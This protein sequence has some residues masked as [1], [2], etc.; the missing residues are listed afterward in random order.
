[1]LGPQAH[2]SGPDFIINEEARSHLNELRVHLAA[3]VGIAP[4]SRY[5][6]DIASMV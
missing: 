3:E 5:T 1:M 6:A 4:A 2:V